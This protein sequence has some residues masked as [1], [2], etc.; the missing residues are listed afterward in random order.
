MLAKEIRGSIPGEVWGG[1]DFLPASALEKGVP[2]CLFAAMGR[3]GGT[4]FPSEPK[5][6]N[7]MSLAKNRAVPLDADNP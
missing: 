5:K 1:A 4:M 7:G 6:F 3:N 2:R